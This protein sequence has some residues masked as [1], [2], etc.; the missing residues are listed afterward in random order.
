MATAL[1]Y[2]ITFTFIVL[3]F[4]V[5]FFNVDAVNITLYPFLDGWPLPLALVFMVGI[6]TGFLWGAL[7][8]W[9]NGGNIRRGNRELRSKL[10][11]LESAEIKSR[12]I[13]P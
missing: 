6:F 10:R 12:S 11:K 3:I 1:K 2:I 8:V 4:W 13:V 9:L 5:C 7:I